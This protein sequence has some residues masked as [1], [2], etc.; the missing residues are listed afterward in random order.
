[1]LIEG[2]DV[3]E[4]DE[5]P[6]GFFLGGFGIEIFAVFFELGGI[7][8]RCGGYPGD[9]DDSGGGCVRV[10]EEGDVTDLHFVPHEVACL[11]VADA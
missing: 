8:I 5:V 11:V 4:I 3:F 6:A 7:R 9:A 1:M 2:D 10:V